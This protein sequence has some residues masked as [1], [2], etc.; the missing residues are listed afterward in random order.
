MDLEKLL[1]KTSESISVHRAFGTAYERDD[2]LIIPVA[3]VA[4]GGG[5]GGADAG[6]DDE[7]SGQSPGGGGGGFG[8][9]TWPVGVYVVKQGDVRWVP[10]I[11]ATRIALAGIAFV[12]ALVK[13]VARRK[14]R[15]R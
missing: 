13:L 11:D 10:A 7:E 8:G 1:T 6:T 14:S 5:G 15:R 9:V 12:R 2:C 4:G 3:F